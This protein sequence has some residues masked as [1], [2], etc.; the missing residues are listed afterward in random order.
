MKLEKCRACGNWVLPDSRAC[1]SC[2]T[3]AP[4]SA[5]SRSRRP[6][7][8][9][10]AI[11]LVL[12]AAGAVT[13]FLICRSRSIDDV[14]VQAL[15]TLTGLVAGW[16]AGDLIAGI[17]DRPRTT[18]PVSI[19]AVPQQSGPAVVSPPTAT[20]AE[21]VQGPTP[22]P[23]ADRIAEPI[24]GPVPEPSEPLIEPSEPLIEPSSEPEHPDELLL[25]ASPGEESTAP[26]KPAVHLHR[27]RRRL[28]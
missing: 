24:V 12:A 14:V 26:P 23:A 17:I 2:G 4:V 27:S 22:E 5:A 3:A 1:P 7:A 9:G 21:P 13:G 25:D 6:P 10:S 11:I 8:G 16:L 15:W 19:T 28:V 18:A 20:V